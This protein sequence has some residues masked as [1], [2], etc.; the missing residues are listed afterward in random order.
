MRE[1]IPLLYSAPIRSHL[2]CC[3]Q[4]WASQFKKDRDLLEGVQH[5]ATKMTKG[6]EHL[7]Y[8]EGLSN[9]GL[10]SMGK[11]RLRGDAINVYKYLKEGGRQMDEARL[12]PVL[13]SEKTRSNALKLA[14]RKC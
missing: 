6:L 9:L 10:F 11:I 2:D 8:E 7:P 4:F 14:Q 5:R 12:F 1:V 13:Y 3:V